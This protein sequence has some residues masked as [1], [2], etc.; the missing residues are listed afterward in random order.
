MKRTL[1]ISLILLA[2]VVACEENADD[3]SYEMVTTSDHI[4]TFEEL[5]PIGFKKNKEYDISRLEGAVRAVNGFWSTDIG[6][7]EYELRFYSS[8]SV[9]VSLGEP[10][11]QEATGE[12]AIIKKS[13]ATWKEGI[14]DRRRSQRT[15]GSH[16]KYGNYSIYGNIV[17]LCEGQ[18]GISLEVCWK[19]INALEKLE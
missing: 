12:D 17:M 5:E 13:D 14:K 10:L 18:V 9:A 2:L 3:P 8:H 6:K 1:I 15:S 19:L 11:A 7:K 4:F 16:P